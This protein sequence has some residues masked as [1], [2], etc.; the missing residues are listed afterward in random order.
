MS[1][2]AFTR[3]STLG[4]ILDILEEGGGSVERVFQAA[5]LPLQL[6]SSP[7]ALIPLRDQ[8]KVVEFAARELGDDTLPARLA[9]AVGVAGLGTY[10]KLFLSA[11]TLRSAIEQGNR[12][13]TSTLQ[14]ATEM[15]LSIDGRWAQWTY[16]VTDTGRVGRQKNEIL[17]VGYMVDLLRRFCGSDWMPTRAAVTP[18]QLCGRTAIEQIFRCDLSFDTMVSMTFPAEYLDVPGP[19]L[20]PDTNSDDRHLPVVDDFLSCV[21]E[22]VRLGLLGGRPQRAWIARRLGMS[23]RT[24][25]RRLCELDT[26]YASLLQTII[27]E[28]AIELIRR[29]D[30][31]ISEI[32]YDLG[33]SDPAHFT[34]AFTHHFG[35]SPSNWRRG[36][37]KQ[38]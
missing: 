11:P 10:G 13:Y 15:R 9:T 16:C 18:G 4:P 24:L 8:F 28:Q 7:N 21:Q 17:A 32:A 36:S 29:R 37:A 27:A 33:Y 2:V 5:E 22:L 26:S 38:T 25:Q 12:I 3:A 6:C 14:S 23:L 35:Q 31:P 19:D 1:G 20:K 30:V 34:R